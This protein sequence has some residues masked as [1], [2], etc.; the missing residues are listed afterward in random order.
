M[1]EEQQLELKPQTGKKKLLIIIVLAVLV[2]IGGGVGAWLMLAGGDKPAEG[3]HGAQTEEEK[4][5][6]AAAKMA[7]YV[8]LPRP[9]VFN[10]EAKPRYRLVQI[11]VALMVRGPANEALAKLH[12]PLVEG[13]LFKVF[14]MATSE[15]LARVEGRKKLKTDALVAV[16]QALHG[17]ADEN[18]VE[19]VLFTGFVMQ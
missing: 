12:T 10:V 17:V 16:K 13:A 7:L 18:V 11:K 15:Q 6:E 5:A 3:E 9:F 1:A 19:Q 14:S 2:L 8:V 4:A